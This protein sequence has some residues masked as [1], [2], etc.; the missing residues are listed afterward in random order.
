[1]LGL[2]AFIAPASCRLLTCACQLGAISVATAFSASRFFN[3][4]LIF[5]NR[6]Y[7][8]SLPAGTNRISRRHPGKTPRKHPLF[9]PRFLEPPPGVKLTCED[10]L[11]SISCAMGE[12]GELLRKGP[13]HIL[14]NPLAGGGSGGRSVP[15]IRAFLAGQGIAAQFHTTQTAPEMERIAAEAIGR[16]ARVLLAMGGD[17]TLQ[18]LVNAVFLSDVVLGI[19][20]AGGGN[21]FAAALGLPGDALAAAGTILSGSIRSVDLALAR[22]ADGRERFYCGGGGVGLDAVAARYAAEVYGRV[23]GRMR[24]VLA[25]LSALRNYSAVTVRAEFPGSELEPVEKRV[26]VAAALNTPTYGAG[27]RLAPLAKIDD[28]LLDIVFVEDLRAY[29]VVPVVFHW[30]LRGE[31]RTRKMAR[32]A[33]PR[34]RIT[35]DQRCMF[36]GDGEILGPAPVEIEVVARAVRM[37]AA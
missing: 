3:N 24:Y 21:D 2:G 5:N 34:V 32:F 12:S 17:G 19:L 13:V 10:A 9:P 8:D 11:G 1:M 37:L 35:T 31:L 36:H 18:T 29:E 4:L 25:A 14:V 6:D 28:G 20:P 23:P 26:L 7:S 33:A 30:A 15:R 22:T 16:G 27:L